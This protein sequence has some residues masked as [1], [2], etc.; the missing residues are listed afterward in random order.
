MIS[1]NDIKDYLYEKDSF[2]NL[3]IASDIAIPNPGTITVDDNCQT[4]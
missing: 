3:L 1:I 2:K 4:H